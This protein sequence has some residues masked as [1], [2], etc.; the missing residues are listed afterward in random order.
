[1]NGYDVGDVNRDKR[2]IYLHRKNITSSVEEMEATDERRLRLSISRRIAT[3]ARAS[4]TRM[5][6]ILAAIVLTNSLNSVKI[7]SMCLSQSSLVLPLWI[8]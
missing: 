3:D 1:M 4:T 6:H 5:R 7:V 8:G 2:S